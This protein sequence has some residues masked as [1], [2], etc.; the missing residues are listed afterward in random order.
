M[1]QIGTEQEKQQVEKELAEL[2]ERLS[3]VE[4][5]AKRREE[6]ERELNDVLVDGGD[7]LEPPPYAEQAEE[8]QS[9]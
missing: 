4:T 6:I 3:Q 2:R 7:V 5:W 9:S 8:T 1:E